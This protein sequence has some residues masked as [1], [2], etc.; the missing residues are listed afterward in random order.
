MRRLPYFD[1]Q[2]VAAAQR[3]AQLLAAGVSPRAI[4]KKLAGLARLL[5]GVARPL[6]QLSSSFKAER[7]YCGRATG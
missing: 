7:S 5:P 3:L 2:E 6:A 1:F 4:E